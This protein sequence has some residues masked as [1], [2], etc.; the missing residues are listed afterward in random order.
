MQPTSWFLAMVHEF[1]IY[2]NL[3]LRMCMICVLHEDSYERT[4][5]RQKNA[6]GTQ[7]R[8]TQMDSSLTSPAPKILAEKQEVVGVC[9]FCN[10]Y[11]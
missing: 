9:Y 10:P 2:L 6:I 1:F 8:Y 4:E 3:C 5:V 7:I 11:S